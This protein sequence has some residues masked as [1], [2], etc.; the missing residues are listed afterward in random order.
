MRNPKLRR[1]RGR[2]FGKAPKRLFTQRL[3][4]AAPERPKAIRPKPTPAPVLVVPPGQTRYQR[5]SAGLPSG[6]AR[7]T[8]L[9][10]AVT[11]DLTESEQAAVETP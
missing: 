10:T 4:A 2:V 3:E 8:G 6:V 11:V 7:F 1:R 5:N 9:G